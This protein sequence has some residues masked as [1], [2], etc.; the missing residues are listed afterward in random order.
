M[1]T[2][3]SDDVNDKTTYHQRYHD[4]QKSD[5]AENHI[6]MKALWSRMHEEIS[7]FG[8]DEIGT[9]IDDAK[10][11]QLMNSELTAGNQS[12]PIPSMNA[13]KVMSKA[14][15]MFV[16]DLTLRA[17]QSKI[18]GGDTLTEEDIIRAIRTSEAH[19]MF[20]P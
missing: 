8:K 2:N 5:I 19:D 9:A 10:L 18:D 15:E 1:N 17:C 13:V 16:L 3:V 4:V 14:C 7:R 11:L 6:N 20:M 12:S